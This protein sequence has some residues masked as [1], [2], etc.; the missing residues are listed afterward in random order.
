MS[1][2]SCRNAVNLS[3]SAHEVG[4]PTTNNDPAYEMM[5]QGGGGGEE[6]GGEGEGEGGGKEEQE[7]QKDD[8][9]C[10]TII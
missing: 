2:F 4:A 3:M 10:R 6:G 7:I 8:L 9:T 5:E 1:S